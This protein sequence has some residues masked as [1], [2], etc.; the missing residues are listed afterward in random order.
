MSGFFSW[1]TAQANLSTSPFACFKWLWSILSHLNIRFDLLA[2]WIEIEHCLYVC[3]CVWVFVRYKIRKFTP[4]KVHTNGF[5]I[6]HPDDLRFGFAGSTLIYNVFRFICADISAP[7]Y[8][9]KFFMSNVGAQE[10]LGKITKN[11]RYTHIYSPCQ[12]FLHQ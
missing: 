3:M 10:A 1:F 7:H 4:D 12:L 9:Y 5:S 6:L 8:T 11:R 2:S